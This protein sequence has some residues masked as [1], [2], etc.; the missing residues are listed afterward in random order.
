V[1]LAAAILIARGHSAADAMR[2]L[3]QQRAVADP[4]IWY[5]RRQIEAFEREW[6]VVIGN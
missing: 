1:A 2:L 5:I 4:G 3:R 6:K